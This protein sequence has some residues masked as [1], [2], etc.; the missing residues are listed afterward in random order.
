MKK[1]KKKKN[2]SKQNKQKKKK[3][4]A[5]NKAKR[6]SSK[7]KKNVLRVTLKE[8]LQSIYNTVNMDTTCKG[9]CECCKVAMP[10]MNFCEYLQ[11][12]YEIW[13][14]STSEEKCELICTSIKYFFQ[15]EFDKWGMESLVKPCM[16]LDENNMCRHYEA[17]PLNCRLYGLWPARDYKR[18]V[19]KFVRAYKGLLKRRELP[20]HKQCPH[21]KRVDTSQPLTSDVINAMFTELDDLDAKLEGFSEVQI[22]EKENYRTFHD[23]LLFTIFG[24]QWLS[25]MTSF[26]LAADKES[27]LDQVAQLTEETRT[28]FVKNMPTDLSKKDVKDGSTSEKESSDS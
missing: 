25:I 14:S 11:L 1:P 13:E 24:E 8:K 27:M 9:R 16:L 15:N 7:S 3:K 21:V 10:Q 18:R 28:R 19:D 23:W 6:G 22:Q 26:V 17:R 4:R 12:H 5:A 2:L 20:L